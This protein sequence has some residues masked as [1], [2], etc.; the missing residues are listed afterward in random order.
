M[1]VVVFIVIIWISTQ[2][3]KITL[4][5]PMDVVYA[6]GIPKFLIMGI[7]LA[8]FSWLFGK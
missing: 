3:V 2:L 8:L 4:I 5:L 1:S 7:I 6:L